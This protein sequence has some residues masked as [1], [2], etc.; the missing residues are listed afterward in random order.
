MASSVL[1]VSPDAWS[2][3][4][5]GRRA[6]GP[7]R[8]AEA[9]LLAAALMAAGCTHKTQP[10][11]PPPPQVG[12]V[13]LGAEP[14]TITAELA[15]RTAA[16]LIADVRPQ[17]DGILKARL[18]KEG[19]LVHAGQA[20]YQID[21]APFL[22]ARDQAAGQLANARAA[23]IADRLQAERNLKLGPRYGVAQQ[24]VDNSVAIARQAE[25]TVRQDEAALRSA[26][27]N[28][29]WS[30]VRAPITGRIGRSL[31]TQGDLVAANQANAL[32][33]IIALDPI[34]V[35]VT[36]SSEAIVDLRRALAHG[37]VLPASTR[38]SL[39][40]SDGTAYARDGVL[41][42]AEVTVDQNSGTVT[43][44]ARFPNPDGL[45]L[46]GMFVRVV[47]PQGLVPHG[48]LAPQQGVT[49]TPTGGATAFVI[50]PD[51]RIVQRELQLGPAVGNTWL[52]TSG[53]SAGDR[54]VVEGVGKVK[55]GAAVRGVPVTLP[56]ME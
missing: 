27:I 55:P 13:Q 46:P 41:E 34:F 32:S 33:T 6:R 52:V 29:A 36:Q 38:V 26:E 16:P 2:E 12:Y 42:F 54:L 9:V 30:T 15:G 21:P 5:G 1:I 43:L 37:H 3:P 47:T 11:P 49:R 51:G 56:K 22:A 40:F 18:F 25:A 50:G 24:T 8:P 31:A 19:A 44:R 10:A 20:L 39:R 28:L 53:L 14:V 7:G 23:V 48:I 17:V 45:L 35:D 4:C